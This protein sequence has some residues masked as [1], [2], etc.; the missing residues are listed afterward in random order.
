MKK[1]LALN[2][3]ISFS[4][5]DQASANAQLPEG[6]VV[7][8]QKPVDPVWCNL[9]NSEQSLRHTLYLSPLAH[10][11]FVGI[12]AIPSNRCEMKDETFRRG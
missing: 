2:K 3:R 12:F 1:G 9:N 7:E 11:I 6:D 4:Y 10:E 5:Q 8:P